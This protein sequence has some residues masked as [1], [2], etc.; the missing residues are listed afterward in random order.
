MLDRDLETAEEA[1]EDWLDTVELWLEAVAEIEA[2][3]YGGVPEAVLDACYDDALLLEEETR[4][5]F[6]DVAW[7]DLV[8]A[9]TRRNT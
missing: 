7:I 3:R 8:A 4:Y 1:I 5:L 2:H 9:L 6:D